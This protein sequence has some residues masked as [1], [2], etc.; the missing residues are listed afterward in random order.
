MDVVDVT[1][2]VVEDGD[3]EVQEVEVEK[4]AGMVG[5]VDLPIRAS[6]RLSA[7]LP[8]ATV[9]NYEYMDSA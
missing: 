2:A 4:D 6:R 7:A 3:T 1:Q 5:V 8:P 9:W